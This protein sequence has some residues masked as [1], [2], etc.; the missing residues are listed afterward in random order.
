MSRLEEI[1]IKIKNSKIK[2]NNL[3]RICHCFAEDYTAIQTAAIVGLSRQTIN[4]YYKLF[5]N[6]LMKQTITSTI[7]NNVIHIKHLNIYKQDVFFIENTQGILI[8]NENLLLPACLNNFLDI[9]F[10]ENLIN[11]KK[12]NSARILFNEDNEKCLLSAFLKTESCFEIF[13]SKRLKQFRGINKKNFLT[14]LKES[15]YRFNFSK[16][17]IYENLLFS[18]HC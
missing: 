7:K 11:H 4:N 5:R 18:F 12:A 17:H 8:L 6:K 3:K 1:T 16:E 14:H 13:L 9:N 15:Q 10:K 2:S